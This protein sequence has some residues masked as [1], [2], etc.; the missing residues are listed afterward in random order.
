MRFSGIFLDIGAQCFAAIARA[1]PPGCESSRTQLR[2]HLR[3]IGQLQLFCSGAAGQCS[4]PSHSIFEDASTDT[5]LGSLALSEGEHFRARA[6]SLLLGTQ[7]I[8]LF[9]RRIR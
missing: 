9:A 4:S 5:A 7:P 6:A 3:F 1:H 2:G 8:R